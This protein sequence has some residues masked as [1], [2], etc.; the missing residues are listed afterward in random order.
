MTKW[1]DLIL[2]RLYELAVVGFRHRPWTL[3]CLNFL[4][5]VGRILSQILGVYENLSH[6]GMLIPQMSC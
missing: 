3:L 2:L 5:F 1:S 4:S 6:S